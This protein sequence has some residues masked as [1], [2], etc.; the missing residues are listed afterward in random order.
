MGGTSAGEGVGKAQRCEQHGVSRH[1]GFNA[2]PRNLVYPDINMEL[3]K[4]F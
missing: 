3:L 2:V 4:G 1:T